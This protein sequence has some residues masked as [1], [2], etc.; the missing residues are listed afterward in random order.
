ML[1]VGPNAG[2]VF[3]AAATAAPAG[4]AWAVRRSTGL[5]RAAVSP[6]RADALRLP[7]MYGTDR[8]RRGNLQTVTVDAVGT[9]TGISAVLR[10][11]PLNVLADPD[12]GTAPGDLL[13]PGHAL[14]ELVGTEPRKTVAGVAAEAAVR[15]CARA[16]LPPVAVLADVLDDAGAP[17]GPARACCHDANRSGGRS[18][19]LRGRSSAGS[20]CPW[21]TAGS[22]SVSAADR[23]PGWPR[24]L[25]HGLLR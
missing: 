21:Q 9:G 20:P 12:P 17:I 1:V 24:L 8:C 10:A 23:A 25:D 2:W 16:G 18:V 19:A 5:L 22:G 7:L 4:I 6:E 15:L 14:V 3:L 13:A 11:R